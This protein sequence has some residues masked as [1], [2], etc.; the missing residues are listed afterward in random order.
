M[1]KTKTFKAGEKSQDK[2]I[3]KEDMYAPLKQILFYLYHL[4]FLYIRK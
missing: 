2:S 3:G 1:T 4:F